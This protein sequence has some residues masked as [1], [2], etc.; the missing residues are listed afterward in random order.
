MDENEEKDQNEEKIEEAE[1]PGLMPEVEHAHGHHHASGVPWLDIV[2]GISVIFISVLSLVVS[3]KHGKTMEKM[4]EQNQKLVAANTLPLLT[5]SSGNVDSSTEKM[6]IDL[7]LT[8]GGVGPAIIDKFELIYKGVNYKGTVALFKACCAEAMKTKI[9]NHDSENRV[10]DNN[11]TGLIL[12]P[13]EKIDV[14]TVD[15]NEKDPRLFQAFDQVRHEIH[16]TACYC[17]VLD[18]CW[19][20]H[21]DHKRPEPVASCKA[22]PGEILW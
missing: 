14:I 6:R 4:V 8:N 17:S 3:I 5:F 11:I 15:F 2:I 13:H 10:M 9:G 18:E 7:T 12:T 22:T 16:A 1:V 19:Q 21:F 20:T